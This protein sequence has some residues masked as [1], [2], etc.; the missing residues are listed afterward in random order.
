MDQPSLRAQ[1]TTHSDS[2][3]S[4][5]KGHSIL[6]IATI[7]AITGGCSG[8][9]SSYRYPGQDQDDQREKEEAARIERNR[10]YK[11]QREAMLTQSDLRL[12]NGDACCA[13]QA[14]LQR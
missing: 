11:V 1:T 13:K 10:Q 9:W 6:A 2:R 5:A 4:R 7:L 8:F 12:C 3:L 14:E